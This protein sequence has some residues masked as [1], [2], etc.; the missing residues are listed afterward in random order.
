MI[1][2][3]EVFIKDL[4]GLVDQRIANR[5]HV[6]IRPTLNRLQAL[7][8]EIDPRYFVAELSIAGDGA[9]YALSFRMEK[10]TSEHFVKILD[11]V[12]R[13]IRSKLNDEFAIHRTTT[14]TFSHIIIDNYA[15]IRKLSG[16]ENAQ[17]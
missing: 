6:F 17:D 1:D 2:Y 9:H 7:Y 10:S 13:Y 3:E 8:S 5:A 4:V 16:E 12:E 14:D 15:F 11:E